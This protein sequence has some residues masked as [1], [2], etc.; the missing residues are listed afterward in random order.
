[1]GLCFSNVCILCRAPDTLPD[2]NQNKTPEKSS[3]LL[4]NSIFTY[5]IMRPSTSIFILE[6][7][8]RAHLAYRMTFKPV[9]GKKHEWWRCL[10]SS[11]VFVPMPSSHWKEGDDLSH[12]EAMVVT[13]WH[14]NGWAVADIFVTWYIETSFMHQLEMLM[15][16]HIKT[17]ALSLQSV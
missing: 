16:H 6:I 11:L 13:V 14:T 2:Q 9:Y 7:K 12:M 15:R 17:I 10:C 3:P 8:L 4:R 5:L 1:M